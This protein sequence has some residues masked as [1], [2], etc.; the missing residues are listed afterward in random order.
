[1]AD[2]IQQQIDAL[3]KS[4]ADMGGVIPEHL[5]NGYDVSRVKY[6]D[7]AEKKLWIYHTIQGT[8]AAT[9]T[10]YGVFYIVPMAC[11]ITKIQ[12]VH[13]TLGT[14][15][16]AVTLQ[17]EKLTGTQALDAGAVALK[18]ALSLKAAINTVQTGTLTDTLENRTLDMGNRLAMKDAGTLTAVANVTVLVELTII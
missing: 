11:V 2:D 13:Q 16:S 14:D 17:I 3:K 12:E 5:H 6:L 15:G 4:I 9:A 18:T 7:L 1:M 10:N 8:A